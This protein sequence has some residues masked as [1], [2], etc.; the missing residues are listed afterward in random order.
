[1]AVNSPKL[2][3]SKIFREA[4]NLNEIEEDPTPRPSSAA[5]STGDPAHLNT[6]KMRRGV[7][8][9]EEYE[10]FTLYYKKC[11]PEKFSSLNYESQDKNIIDK[12]INE[13]DKQKFKHAYKI[14]KINNPTNNITEFAK[15]LC[16]SPLSGGSARTTKRKAKKR[17]NKRKTRR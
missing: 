4:F 8:N 17:H 15:E 9:D 2:N 6:R 5:S 13:T 11:Y 16:A 10:A 3:A 1:M 12:K 7:L 14:W